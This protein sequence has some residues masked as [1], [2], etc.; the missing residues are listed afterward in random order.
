[1]T[2]NNFGKIKCGLISLENY[3]LFSMEENLGILIFYQGKKNS[4]I[5]EISRPS[6]TKSWNKAL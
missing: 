4:V 3:L 6:L 2:K 5:R 1:M